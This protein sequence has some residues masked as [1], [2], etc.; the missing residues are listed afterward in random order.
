MNLFFES[1]I[2]P[3]Q[4]GERP[5]TI[6]GNH[7]FTILPVF[8]ECLIDIINVNNLTD[9]SALKMEILVRYMAFSQARD[10]A[11][12]ELNEA[13]YQKQV[14]DMT[15]MQVMYDGVTQHWLHSF[16]F[17]DVIPTN[18]Q[19]RIEK[20]NY[21][22]LI[23][24]HEK[25]LEQ[26]NEDYQWKTVFHLR[27]TFIQLHASNF[28]SAYIEGLCQRLCVA[29]FGDPNV[30][31]KAFIPYSFI[32]NLWKKH[33]LYFRA[34]IWSKWYVLIPW[35][36]KYLMESGIKFDTEFNLILEGLCGDGS[37][38]DGVGGT[39]GWGFNAGMRE[40]SVLNWAG[41]NFADGPYHAS[42]AQYLQVV[43]PDTMQGQE[44]KSFVKW[45][46]NRRR[47]AV[48]GGGGG[49]GGDG[50]DDDEKGQDPPDMEDDEK[51]QD[52]GGLDEG[53]QDDPPDMEDD[54][55][56]ERKNMGLF[57]KIALGKGI[58]ISQSDYEGKFIKD[59]SAS[60]SPYLLSGAYD[61]QADKNFKMSGKSAID[62]IDINSCFSRYCNDGAFR[63]NKYPKNP[64]IKNNCEFVK[65]R[66]KRRRPK[67]ALMTTKKIKA[68]SELFVAYGASYWE[69]YLEDQTS[70]KLQQR[71]VPNEDPNRKLPLCKYIIG[72]KHKCTQGVNGKRATA[73]AEGGPY[74]EF[75][76]INSPFVIKVSSIQE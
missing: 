8:E 35:L 58:I 10:F 51:G 68:D 16:V 21:M 22:R 65:Y 59:S 1:K 55:K 3:F 23:R 37:V 66:G 18:N 27:D 62:A 52:E 41:N 74:C 43:W 19:L 45:L 38:P 40:L 30:D 2:R 75:H 25:I 67:F 12:P 6:H 29:V 49:E 26:R 24:R 72:G 61:V 7:A 32:D 76:Y 48:R 63:N 36:L 39:L 14:N 69:G 42:C 28:Q 53:G 15:G 20:K 57:T 17:D 54:E 9:I 73:R 4:Y 64:N 44:W 71:A 46:Y 56:V 13:F 70:G 50:G 47:K 60:D 11:Y 34:L 31:F 33:P 5:N